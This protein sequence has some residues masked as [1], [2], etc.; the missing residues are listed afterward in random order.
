MKQSAVC[1]RATCYIRLPIPGSKAGAYRAMIRT[2]TLLSTTCLTLALFAANGGPDQYGYT[3]KDSDEPDGPVYE[4]IDITTTG[5]QVTGLADDNIVGPYVLGE[6]FPFYWYSVKK[7][8]VGSNGYI[9]FTTSGNIAASFPNIPM[10][11]ETDNYVAGYMTDLNFAGA[12]N[13]GQ[14]WAYDDLDRTIFSYIN[15]PYWDAAAPE[16]WSGS[17]TFQ[18]VLDKTDSTITINY[19][20]TLCCSGSNGPMCGIEALNGDIGLQQNAGFVYPPANFSV[21]YYMPVVPL[22]DIYDASVE[23]VTDPTN[24]GHSIGVDG[25]PFPLHAYL[26]NSGNQTLEPFTVTSTI[27]NELNQTVA[28]DATN[29]NSMVPNETQDIFFANSF[30]PADPGTYRSTTTLNGVPNESVT[31]NNSITQEVVAYDTTLLNN[32]IDWAGQFDD[33]IG[34]GWTGGQ[35]GCGAYILP[36]FYPIYVSHTT[37]RIMSNFGN[38]GFFMKVYDDDGEDGGV[39][40]LLDSF[41]VAPEDGQAGDHAYALAEPFMLDSGGLYVQWYMDGQNVNLAQDINPPFSLRSYEVI[42]GAWANYRDR[43]IADF[44]LGLRMGFIPTPDAGAGSIDQPDDGQTIGGSTAVRIWLRNYGNVPITGIPCN[45][46]FN[47]GSAVSQTY[48]G[49]AISPGDSVLFMFAQ[50]LI[51]LVEASGALCAWTSYPNDLTSDNDTSCVNISMV[52]GVEESAGV[53]LRMSPVPTSSTLTIDGLPRA[54]VRLEVFDMTGALRMDKSLRNVTGPA[55][56]NVASLA[57]GA[58]VL[59]AVTDTAQFT[60]RFVVQR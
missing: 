28:V 21:R 12:G 33:G 59:R 26:R 39:G 27:L 13:P 32:D 46:S 40:T 31:S 20:N 16:L 7:I 54:S 22:L 47:G 35:A 44:H 15:V 48:N 36:P 23:W 10:A 9:T 49:P 53:R 55:V 45:Y 6:N 18:I 52:V 56:L 4:W 30:V 38:V 8:F 5:T 60:G 1:F 41:Y 2:A 25:T 51:P 19:Q 57:N 37:C 17:N 43:E 11:G 50:P 42:Q 29:V 58:Y 34:I 24:G 14:L 3:W